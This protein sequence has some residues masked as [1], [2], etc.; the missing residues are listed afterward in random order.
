MEMGTPLVPALS[1]GENN[2]HGAIEVES[3]VWYRLIKNAS[4]RYANCVPPLH[5]GRFGLVPRRHPITTVIGEPIELKKTVAPTS[6]EI[7][8]TFELFCKRLTELF[9]TQKSKYIKDCE[10]IHLEIV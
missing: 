10:H 2:L 5:N 6:D 4:L 3:G 8:Q 7:E 1:F 9:D